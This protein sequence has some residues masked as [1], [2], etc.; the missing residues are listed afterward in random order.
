MSTGRA[1]AC[2]AANL[3]GA[4]T[5]AYVVKAVK[6]GL[7]VVIILSSGLAPGEVVAIVARAAC[8]HV[9]R[10]PFHAQAEVNPIIAIEG[11]GCRSCGSR[12]WCGLCWLTNWL[13][14][15]GRLLFCRCCW[16]FLGM[17]AFVLALGDGE[18]ANGAL[19]AGGLGRNTQ[20]EYC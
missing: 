1:D 17:F 13:S 8:A 9:L 6:A 4:P 10:R 18:P 7:P 2:L 16:L 14:R 12:N 3:V 19:L 20:G 11:A 15:L 5:F